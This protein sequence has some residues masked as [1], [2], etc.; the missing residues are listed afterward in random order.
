MKTA[1]AYSLAKLLGM[2]TKPPPPPESGFL[3]LDGEQIAFTLIRSHRRKHT[4]AFKMERNASLRIM[5][6]FSATLR[7][8]TKILQKRAPWIARERADRKISMPE[9]DFTN[10]AIFPYLGYACTLRI[11]QGDKAPRSCRL[12]PHLLHVHVP[13]ENLSPD[14]LRQEVRLEL[15][16]WIKKRARIKLK[17]RL[18]LWATKMDVTYKKLMITGPER[19]WGSCSVDNIIRLNWRLMMAPLPILDYVA[20]H[21]L[22]HIRHKNHS[23]RFWSFLAEAMPDSKARRKALRHLESRLMP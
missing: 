18:D 21:E 10:G 4:I 19:R 15:L 23:P 11:T 12:S 3:T 20:A 9:N 14:N 13:D 6:P 2:T 22:S 1:I 5:A 17:K 16:L 8:V 7:S